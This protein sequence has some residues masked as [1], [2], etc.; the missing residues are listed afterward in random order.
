MAVHSPQPVFVVGSFVMACC[1]FTPHLPGRGEH[2]A[3]TGFFMEPGGKGLNVAV[4]LK[5]LGAP[6]H[7]LLGVGRDPARET[8]LALLQQ[9]GMADRLVHT[10]DGASGHGAGLIDASGEHL[11]VVH[12]GANHRLEPTHATAA[13]AEI[14]DSAIVYGQFEV[15]D[16]VL[17]QAFRL[18][19]QAGARTVLN[20]SPWRALD[21]ALLQHTD[22]L[23]LNEHEAAALFGLDAPPTAE[24][25]DWLGPAQAWCKAHPGIELVITLGA[26]GCLSWAAHADRPRHHAARAIH[27][28][29]TTGCGD[30]F[31]AAW[32]VAQ[33]QAA[34]TDATLRL[35]NSAGAWLAARAGVI[36]ALPTLSE[37]LAWAEPQA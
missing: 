14:A 24:R 19:R 31:S 5:R 25:G 11:I 36:P 2:V 22:V 10:F 28:V 18:G 27:A 16:A 37:L 21:D 26:A 35:A 23:I 1:W 6:V 20:P 34:D 17:T 30:A 8:L 32:C 15:P 13:R 7:L 9:E 3:A 4:G 33:A 12:P 29:D